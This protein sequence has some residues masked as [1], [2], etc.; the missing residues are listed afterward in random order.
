[1][2]EL[3]SIDLRIWTILLHLL[4]RRVIT[5]IFLHLSFVTNLPINV[6]LLASD[7]VFSDIGSGKRTAF[8]TESSSKAFCSQWIGRSHA[9]LT[10]LSSAAFFYMNF[11]CFCFMLCTSRW[12]LI[13][14][15]CFGTFNVSTASGSKGY[16][17]QYRKEEIIWRER[18]PIFFFQ[19]Q[20]VSNLP[21]CL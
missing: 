2:Q 19:M 3:K 10:G 18:R 7:A 1:M 13:L 17:P 5:Y 8:V 11:E 12:I 6:L 21:F 16:M 4:K 14:W 15:W 9:C 20:N